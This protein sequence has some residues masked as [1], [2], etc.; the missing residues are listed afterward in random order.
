M[1]KDKSRLRT[2]LPLF[3]A[4]WLVAAV[5]WIIAKMGTLDSERLLVPIRLEN[6]PPNVS[7]VHSPSTSPL[8]VKYPHGLRSQ[9]VAPN[10]EVRADVAELLGPDPRTWAGLDE[11]Q[12]QSIR[13]TLDNVHTLNLPQSV[14]VSAMEVS[15]I[16][17]EA[18]LLSRR[19]PIRAVLAGQ[20]PPNFEMRGEPRVEPP[21]ILLTGS[22]E[23]LRAYAEPTAEV[24]TVPVALD[25]R[26]QDFLEYPALELPAGVEPVEPERRIQVAVSIQEK[27]RTMALAEVPISITVFS[28]GLA[29]KFVPETAEIRVRAR[30]SV[31]D[32]LAPSMFMF[33]PKEALAEEEG[34]KKAI[35]LDLQISGDAP[36]AVRLGTTIEDFSPRKV[37]VE[38]L[39]IE[40]AEEEEER[41]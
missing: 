18:A 23:A 15:R 3:A 1:A 9:I 16:Q 5:I 2:E 35:E 14:R 26:T 27:E 6:V 7:I 37:E 21:T 4:A 36:E 19:V 29:A 22:A 13:V 11:P 33:T 30:G 28:Q 12:I 25:S 40:P 24:R 32:Q 20:P 41:P 38:F 17:L 10:F 39:K 34:T 31:L 8:T